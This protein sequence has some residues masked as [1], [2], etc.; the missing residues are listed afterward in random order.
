[1]PAMNILALLRVAVV[2]AAAALTACA[3]STATDGSLAE[4]PPPAARPS[5]SART[6]Y[7]PPPPPPA[8]PIQT[9][10][11]TV[12]R[13][14]GECWMKLEADRK[15]PRDLDR[16]VMLVETCAAEKMSAATTSTQ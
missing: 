15:A 7:A 2:I 16:R 6:T 11:M 9:A 5:A 12:E 4:A 13:A 3:Q 14:R 10:A 1:M 8:P